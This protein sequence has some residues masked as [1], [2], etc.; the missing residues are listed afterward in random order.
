MIDQ[1]KQTLKKLRIAIDKKNPLTSR[2]YKNIS[3]LKDLNDLV[4][5][6]MYI[7][8]IRQGSDLLNRPVQQGDALV[9][10]LGETSG[11][12]YMFWC[13]YAVH[14]IYYR[15]GASSG[16]NAWQQIQ[17]TTVQSVSFDEKQLNES[18]VINDDTI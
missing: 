1:L 15:F 18:D 10:V 16:W 14:E 6:G 17:M 5:P 11:H 2:E 8:K 12:T 9:F 4:E 7:D 13:M 3:N